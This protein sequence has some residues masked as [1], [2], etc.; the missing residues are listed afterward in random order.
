MLT[1]PF[2][3]TIIIS[4]ARPRRR[5]PYSV[6][7]NALLC[8]CRARRCIF[9]GH[10]SL[11]LHIRSLPRISPPP[12]RPAS[13]TSIGSHLYVRTSVLTHPVHLISFQ[14]GAPPMDFFCSCG[15]NGWTFVYHVQFVIFSL[16]SD[17][18]LTPRAGLLVL[19]AD[20]RILCNPCTFCAWVHDSRGRW[21]VKR[22]GDSFLKGPS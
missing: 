21:T 16:L 6:T 3:S 14:V 7:I 20:A 18:S 17:S 4:I 15:Q 12:P 1:A 22:T 9:L 11:I 10:H 8:Y 5:S 19:L 2:T 13:F